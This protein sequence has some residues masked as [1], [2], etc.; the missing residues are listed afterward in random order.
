MA[1]CLIK[2][3]EYWTKLAQSGIPELKFYAFANQFVNK[4]GRFPNLDEIPGSNSSQHL[5]ETIHINKNGSAKIEDILGS[6]GVNT[7]E[8][9]NIALNDQHS[10]LE[11]DITPLNKEALV[12][13]K[14]RPSQYDPREPQEFE[15][16]DYANTGVIFNS[17]FNKLRKL[18]GINLIPITNKELA[19]WE[20]IPDVKNV[21]AFIFQNNIYINTDLAD[22]DAPIHEMTHLLLGS[23]RFKNPDLYFELIKIADQFENFNRIARNYPNRTQQDIYEEVFVQ[24]VARYLSGLPSEINKLDS[25]I[26][27]EINYNIKRLLDSALMGRYSVKSLQEE[28]LYQMS[29]K[30]LAKTLESTILTVDNFGS[31]D[32]A[33]VHRVLSN[34][35]SDLMK[36]GDLREECL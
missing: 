33:Q 7:I 4:Y 28:K 5:S 6:T 10:D 15:I 31:M 20:N 1:N 19:T 21:S 35:K 3:S 9:A 17:L 12:N 23:I 14:N 18:Y 32:D 16:S 2:D 27:Y 36:N 13:I 34:K 30:D 22:I 24:E 8:E 26:Q 29:F 11:I 25:T